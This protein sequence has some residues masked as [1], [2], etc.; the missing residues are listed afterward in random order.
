[1]IWY[2]GKLRCTTC[3]RR[4][5]WPVIHWIFYT[6]LQER[7][8]Y[9]GRCCFVP[10]EIIE[11]APVY[12]QGQ[13][14]GK[15][16]E[17]EGIPYTGATGEKLNKRFLP[18][19][20]LERNSDVSITNTIRCRW[21]R[22][23]I[24]TDKLPDDAEVLSRAV[25]H[26][27]RAHRRIPESTRLIVAQGDLAW[28]NLGGSGS[29]H[30]WRGYILPAG[31]PHSGGG[32][33]GPGTDP[34]HAPRL[35]GAHSGGRDVREVLPSPGLGGTAPLLA[36]VHLAALDREYR[37]TVPSMCDWAKIPRILDGSWPQPFPTIHNVNTCDWSHVLDWFNEVI[38]NRAPVV[39][40][41]E[42]HDNGQ[43]WMLGLFSPATGTVL[44]FSPLKPSGPGR[45]LG[46][47][48][49]FEMMIQQC[50]VSM[51]N[52]LADVRALRTSFGY[53]WLDYKRIE[54]PM[55]AHAVLYV[56]YEHKLGFADSCFGHHNKVKH[57]FHENPEL[58]NAGDCWT[59]HYTLQ[60]LEREFETDKASK[61]IY[62]E[63]LTLLPIVD[64]SMQRGIRTNPERVA[65]GIRLY[66]ERAQAAEKVAH[67]YCGYPINVSSNDQIAKWCYEVEKMPVQKKKGRRGE[68]DV[69]GTVGKDAIG[70]LRKRYL[71][72][73]PDDEPNAGYLD[74]R[75]ALGGHP[76]LESRFVNQAAKQNLSHYLYPLLH[77]DGRV[78][79]RVH[80][81]IAIHTQNNARWSYTAPP[82][83]QIP[84]DLLLIYQP[85]EG[86]P[87]EI[88]DWDQIELRQV[89][90]IAR[91]M[92][93]LQQ[94]AEGK[95]VH[96]IAACDV[97][98]IPLPPVLVNPFHSPENEAWK[99][100][101]KWMRCEHESEVCG[102][103]DLR[104]TFGKN[105]QYRQCF[106]LEADP[107][108]AVNMPS[109][110]ALGLTLE[111]MVRATT[112]WKVA[113]PA[114]VHWKHRHVI[115]GKRTRMSRTWHGRLRR[116]TDH[117]ANLND[118]ILDHPSQA[119]TQDIANLTAIQVK[120]EFKDAVYYVYGRHDSQNW[121]IQERFYSEIKPRLH[122]I[123]Q[124]SRNIFGIEIPF[125]ASFK[126]RRAT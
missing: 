58:Y 91:D 117:F 84:Q 13:G 68:S 81:S 95:D 37:L 30:L 73:D 28:K 93:L 55:Q 29:I 90:A 120:K 22:N 47:F 8:P 52:A 26:C 7:S 1:V 3:R 32:E 6:T 72:F 126:T 96:L 57:L 94:F 19:A 112:N 125:P 50:P 53:D 46:F 69:E 101:Y 10:D 80:H 21:Q 111:D 17:S 35:S 102:K 12:V 11:G 74:L 86:W 60:A 79:E 4:I 103:G 38:T 16:E 48:E 64:E 75:I 45:R 82:L 43:V 107:R 2:P 66:E 51:W 44:Q 105:F 71:G 61:T 115:T 124:T 88:F 34:L 59:P 63:H 92:D 83:A 41:T 109:A 113:H 49:Y 9:H 20:G 56:E 33:V 18:L 76:L 122:E 62:E 27:T 97:F 65:E 114:I 104:R 14:P 110:R 119:G 67:A 89:A 15:D 121:G 39:I 40:D 99:R 70:I 85:D 106:S 123:V 25:D 36:T 98:G 42:Y 31:R 78:V 23:G 100:D 77:G 108:S 118:Q 87:W 116:F 54:D 24:A 5:F